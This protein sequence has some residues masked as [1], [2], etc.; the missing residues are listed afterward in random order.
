MMAARGSK[1]SMFANPYLYLYAFGSFS[2]GLFISLRGPILPELATRVGCDAAALGTFLGLCG[3]SGGVFSVPT[4]LLLDR[5][6]PH[7]VRGRE[8]KGGGRRTFEPCDVMPR[9]SSFEVGESRPL[10]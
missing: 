4:G 6:D 7:A 10:G 5:A 3:L 8:G 2:N 9:V 1:P